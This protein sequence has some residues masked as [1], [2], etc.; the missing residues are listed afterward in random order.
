MKTSR[1]LS[2]GSLP[3]CLMNK[4]ILSLVLALAWFSPKMYGAGVMSAAGGG[5]F[6]LT[7]DQSTSKPP[8][9]GWSS[10]TWGNNANLIND[11]DAL[12]TAVGTNE[13]AGIA[14]LLPQSDTQPPSTAG[15]ARY[16]YGGFF[17]QSRP[18]GNAYNILM[19][20]LRNDSGVDQPTLKMSYDFNLFS[21]ANEQIVGWRVFYSLTGAAGS[22]NRIDFFSG[23]TTVGNQSNEVALASPWLVGE[24]L[25]LVWADDNADGNSDPSYTLDNFFLD[26][27]AVPVAIVTQPSS[28]TVTNCRPFSLTVVASGNP[29]YQWYKDG[30]QP[31]NAIPGATAATYTVTNAQATDAGSYF[32]RMANSVNT[33]DSDTVTVTVIPDETPWTVVNAL[34]RCYGTNI[35][36][37]FDELMLLSSL[38][39]TAFVV[40]P[41]DGGSGATVTNVVLNNGTNVVLQ[42]DAALQAEKHYGLTINPPVADCTGNTQDPVAVTLQYELC[43]LDI[44]NYPWKYNFRGENLGEEWRNDPNFIEGDWWSNSVS[45]FDF[46]TATPTRTTVGGFPVA[47]ELPRRIPEYTVDGIQTNIPIYYFR[48]HFNL[49]TAPQEI[50][51]LNLFTLVDDFDAAWLNYDNTP[52][53]R[54]PGLPMTVN[55]DGDVYSGGDAVNATLL[56][57]FPI[58]PALIKYGDNFI[59][60]KLWQSAGG[61]S[62]ETFAYRL[63]AIVNEF[64][65]PVTLSISLSGPNV[66]VTWTDASLNLY[67]AN[68]V[69]APPSGWTLVNPQS[70]GSATVAHGGTAR[71]FSLRQ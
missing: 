14:T 1:T 71:F 43:L 6:P 8:T 60:A 5:F 25:Y 4:L 10:A 37:N 3:Y 35:T 21:A 45:V 51:S 2:V 58:S 52:V 41:L 47:T 30:D 55:L 50:A 32:V 28:V 68:T 64:R 67:Q 36:V 65:V 16:N 12:D 31:A 7:F 61:S 49:P 34:V 53:H 44:V 63:V 66:I 46:S 13:A 56:G 62:D 15:L 59:A 29:T 26:L 23:N 38:E 18:T 17:L 33:L 11:A 27:P 20:T 22:W 69:D 57:P 39:T 24:L 48:T 19:A 9:N 42:L 70:A 54:H 40:T